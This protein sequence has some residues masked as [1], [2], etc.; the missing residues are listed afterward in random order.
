MSAV[1]FGAASDSVQAFGVTFD[2]ATF[3]GGG[4]V[5]NYR[6]RLGSVTSVEQPSV[7]PSEYSLAQNYPNPFNPETRIRYS[8]SQSSRVVLKIFNMLGQE[9]RTLLDEHKPAGSFEVSWDGKNDAGQRVPSGV[10]LYQI[11][12]QGKVMTKKMTLLQ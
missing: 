12:A 2:I 6:N 1:S 3:A 7:L 9:V 5:F 4:Q 11:H 10:Y 8:L